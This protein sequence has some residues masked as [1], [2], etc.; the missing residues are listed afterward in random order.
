MAVLIEDYRQALMHNLWPN[1]N[2][3]AIICLISLIGIYGAFRLISR[4]D[5]VYPR[6][7]MQ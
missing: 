7:T 4:F 6:V 1:L 5:H 2:T 3:L